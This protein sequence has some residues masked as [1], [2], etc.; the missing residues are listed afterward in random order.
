M[1]TPIR[2]GTTTGAGLLARAREASARTL[3][4]FRNNVSLSRQTR[5]LGQR[6]TA[7][8]LPPS[9]FEDWRFDD[10]ERALADA[11][12]DQRIDAAQRSANA[13]NVTP[14]QASFPPPR[15]HADPIA[16]NRAFFDGDHW[17]NGDGWIGPHPANGDADF[18]DAMLEIALSFTSKNA[19]RE[20]VE[21][22][23]LGVVGKPFQ[24]AFVPRREL[25]AD[26]KPTAA[27]QAAI[28]EATAVVR[29]WMTTRKV[30]TLMRNALCTLLL[31]ERAAIRLY[32]PSGLATADGE[33]NSIVVATD[34]ADALT[35][36]FIE[37]P[38]PEHATV[39]TDDDTKLEAGIW[40]FETTDDDDADDAGGQSD[41]D[42]DDIVQRAGLTFL[43]EAR[44]TVLRI[45][46]DDSDRADAAAADTADAGIVA[47]ASLDLGG[48]LPMFEMRR[49]AL[50]TPQ[51][52]Q[53]QRA[54]NLALT[55]IP[56]NVVT[57]GFLERIMLDA[58]MPG[59]WE[60][61]P[62]GQ[63][64][65]RWIR[66]PFYT[67]AGTTNFLTGVEFEDEQGNTKR[68]TPSVHFREPVKPDASITASGAHYAAI[69]DEVGQR[70][71][72]MAGDAAASAV[73]RI[74][75]RFEYLN[76]L[77]LTQPEAET[78]LSFTIETALA[79]A[80]A[81]AR[82]P[83]RYTTL[84][85]AQVACKLDTGPLAPDERAAI[86]ASIGKTLSQATAMTL[87]GV[88]DVASER[89]RM[90][91]D[92]LA[93]AVLGK[94]IGDALQS[95][96]LAGA[97]L[98][99]AAATIGIEGDDLRALMTPSAFATEPP[100]APGQPP[101][102]QNG[103]SGG[104]QPPTPGTPPRLA[105]RG[106]NPNAN[107]GNNASNGGGANASRQQSSSGSSAGGQK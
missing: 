56:R 103:N 43:D 102:N 3:G 77:L 89:A 66:E 55:M 62:D 67:G 21:R 95:L 32:V 37:H 87:L 70:H 45:V 71:V 75:A 86:E 24:W 16:T 59:H 76:T 98:E 50:V 11:L 83:G 60:L 22:H 18:S 7:S 39:A 84:L 13:V 36:I 46:D 90:A 30:P 29:Q 58:Q 34:V 100:P 79:M 94:A 72:L 97:S 51:V 68:G 4:R 28:D 31:A 12:E 101:Q 61:D 91:A 1:T 81:L 85:R 99:G 8:P 9:P 17:Q 2:P 23:T 14:G 49:A 57:G 33:G 5:L 88:D 38:M 69:L 74:Q 54:L 6:P 106:G 15:S 52:Q 20:V 42:D 82:A 63:R 105:R 80:E 40:R 41:N 47:D 26:E 44:Q 104:R 78:A 53:S 10:V 93:R 35:K 96:T 107:G 48:R 27:E 92:P 73:A 19:V 25:K 64:T 65:G